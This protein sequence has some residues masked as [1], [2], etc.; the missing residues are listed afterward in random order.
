MGKIKLRLNKKTL[1]L[2]AASGI[3]LTP[4][5]ASLTNP[6]YVEGKF[7]KEVEQDENEEYGQYVVMENDN[8]SKISEKIC[9]HYHEEVSTKYWPALAFL[10]GYPKVINPG[11]IIIYPK[12]FERLVAM[13]DKLRKI[14]W[15]AKY[16]YNN[17]IYG[18]KK[19]K[20]RLSRDLVGVILDDI[21]GEEVCVDEDFIHLYLEIQGLDDKYY[22]TNNQTLNSDVIYDLTEWI[23]TVEQIN[24]YQENHPKT[25]KK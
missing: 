17:K 8:L 18:E 9:G 22:L 5:E 6:K 11:D 15:T 12:S 24:E 7:V 13:N 25:K 10:N 19:V 21:Y 3:A 2:L 14:G 16:I 20:K 1:A 23:P 4:I